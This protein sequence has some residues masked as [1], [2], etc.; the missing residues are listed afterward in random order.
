[1]P[2]ALVTRPAEDSAAVAGELAQRGFDVLSEPLLDIAPLPHPPVDDRG[3]QGI[4]VTSANGIRTL[5]PLLADRHL[6]VW[7]VGDASAR[8]SR[9]LGFDR[10]V[11]ANGDVNSLSQVIIDRCRPQDGDFLHAAGSVTAGDLSGQLAQA[12]FAVRRL[13]LYEARTATRLTPDLCQSLRRGGVDIALFYSPRTAVTFARLV[14]Q[15]AL[16]DALTGI[17]AYCLS[18]AVAQ[19]LGH[20]PWAAVHTAAH[21]T[22][23]ALLAL[24]DENRGK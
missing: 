14:Q 2:T 3:A 7:T 8:I 16:G 24:L 18:P 15:A 10:V 6:P 21:P 13:V 11:S 1:M 5:A 17:M 23:A 4:L 12:G 20:L 9:Q 22:Q 19:A